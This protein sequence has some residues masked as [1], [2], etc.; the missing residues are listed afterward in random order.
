MSGY[1]DARTQA[2]AILTTE[3][4]RLAA[5]VPPPCAPN[6]SMRKWAAA[7]GA[8]MRMDEVAFLTALAAFLRGESSPEGNPYTISF[9]R[10]QP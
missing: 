9:E 1:I 3:A 5:F 4:Q 2:A 10:K 8:I 7:S 6:D